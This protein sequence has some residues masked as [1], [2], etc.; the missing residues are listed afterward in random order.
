MR[1]PDSPATEQEVPVYRDAVE[2]VNDFIRRFGLA[3]GVQLDPLDAEGYTEARYSDVALGINVNEEHGILMILARMGD[4]PD[5]PDAALLQ[6]LL[7]LNF[8]ATGLC[9]FAIDEQQRHL[10]LR[11]MRPIEPLRYEEFEHLLHSIAG[12]AQSMH[13]RLTG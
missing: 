5:S 2:R 4:L 9:A 3:V 12:M 8:L 1:E 6:R 7:E 11:T 10:V 13:R